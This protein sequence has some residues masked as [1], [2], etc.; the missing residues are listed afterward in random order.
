LSLI[1]DTSFSLSYWN[2]EGQFSF[3]NCTYIPDGKLTVEV[4]VWDA[5]GGNLSTTVTFVVDNT[6]PL[7]Q[8]VYPHEGMHIFE[9]AIYI[10]GTV[11]ELNKG[12]LKPYIND[13]RFTLVE[14]NE[15]SG[16]FSFVNN[17]QL[18]GR[19]S[20]EV[21]FRDLAGNVDFDLV[22]FNVEAGGVK[23]I[24]T[25]TVVTR[26][27]PS[28]HV[29]KGSCFS[30]EGNVYDDDGNPVSG[31]QV[32]IYLATEDKSQPIY[33]CGMGYVTD[34]FFNITCQI[35]KE[36]K[37]GRYQVVAC[38]CGNDIYN[39]SW[40]DPP[41]IVAAETCIE[42]NVSAK[43]IMGRPFRVEGVLKEKFSGDPV[44]NQTVML[45]VGDRNYTLQTD[46]KGI[47][48]GNYTL[49]DPGNY[50][51]RVIFEGTET[52][53]G[54]TKSL[55]IRVLD[56]TIEFTTNSTLV[57]SEA[58]H[59]TGKVHA[60]NLPVDFEDITIMLD[61]TV[62]AETK[63]DGQGFFRATAYIPSNQSLGRAILSYSLKR[64]PR[65]STQNVNIL[66]R[67]SL[68]CHATHKLH[69]NEKFN[70][71]V[72]LTDD[73][74]QP[75]EMA[76]VKLKCLFN[77]EEIEVTNRTNSQGIAEFRGIKLKG[78]FR[79]SFNY[80]V[81]FEG[82]KLYLPCTWT[83]TAYIE[84]EPP[85]FTL[86]IVSTV[87]PA[88]VCAAS[89][90]LWIR[91]RRNPPGKVRREASKA[92]AVQPLTRTG[93]NITLEFPQIR[94]PFPNVW[95]LG[96]PLLIKVRLTDSVGK[97]ISEAT[98]KVAF[99]GEA[100]EATTSA[101]G[102]ADVEKAFDSK[103]IH[104]V[105]ARFIDKNSEEA[106]CEVTLKV[107]DYREE[108]VELFNLFIDRLKAQNQ[109]LRDNMTPRELQA[110]IAHQ[111][112]PEKHDALE[113]AV[114]VFEVANYSLHPITRREYERIFL[115]IREFEG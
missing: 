87:L 26:V 29:L 60:E 20:V 43:V 41:I 72:R 52:Y 28:A 30:V 107:V 34:G 69:S 6:P 101:D 36:V 112:P 51:L 39:P 45:R 110:A 82:N 63:T 97:P 98:V 1:N 27:S 19:V 86:L 91:R 89:A 55:T 9:R 80:T 18:S 95:G 109:D 49:R 50:T 76:I 111:T 100:V 58:A 56:I 21:S 11:R 96:E 78:G 62:I 59:F 108:V 37:V 24:P 23:R 85:N 113:E 32:V 54:T 16:Y 17:T 92:T 104:K 42:V 83:G 5:S 12:D 106:V 81:S 105:S 15:S 40:S 35:G 114:S 47:F 10:N 115:S 65:S 57:R 88:S 31:L 90:L 99:N 44:A 73:K 2:S 79:G 48:T 7:V 93:N 77:G 66:A 3:D 46:G 25:R 71:T 22:T 103:G 38:T 4:S 75:I 102:C 84:A 13:T 8:I 94:D 14:W 70:A 68:A 64:Y 74:G 61:G 67:T 33:E 53:L